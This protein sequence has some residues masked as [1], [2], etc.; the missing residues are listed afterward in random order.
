MESFRWDIKEVL[1]HPWT[2]SDLLLFLSRFVNELRPQQNKLSHRLLNFHDVRCGPLL[3]MDGYPT[4]PLLLREELGR[5]SSC[6][7]RKSPGC[8]RG[9]H[10]LL[11]LPWTT[12]SFR[13][14]PQP[15]APGSCSSLRHHCPP[16]TLVQTQTHTL[17]TSSGSLMRTW[18]V[19][20]R[21]KNVF[22]QS[23][24]AV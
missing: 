4:K 7:W 8:G 15:D 16:P 24:T 17:L 10:C 6:P 11:I 19:H 1:G 5:V 18:A 20:F 21:E 3:R 14:A 9:S 2:R 22:R 13:G 23:K 12:L